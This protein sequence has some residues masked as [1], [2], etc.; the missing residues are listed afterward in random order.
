MENIKIIPQ[1]LRGAISVPP[2]KSLCHRALI[3]ASLC[4]DESI[5]SNISMSQDIKAT[6]SLIKNMGVDL[7]F[8]DSVVKI[9]GSGKLK[10]INRDMD[11]NESGSTLR[12]FIP[13]LLTIGEGVTFSGKGK[14]VERPLQPYYSI[15]DEQD[16]KY[17]TINGMLPLTVEGIL[18]PGDFYIS[19]DVSSQFVT[20]LLFALP[21]LQKDSCIHITS[22]LESSPYVDLT[23]DILK[24]FSVNI[25]NHEYK[26]FYIK[27]KQKYKAINYYVE[28]DYSQAAFW[29]A[30]GVIGNNVT[31]RGLNINSLQGDKVIIDIL[32]EMGGIISRKGDSIT[33]EGSRLNGIS[34]DASQCP[35]LVPILAV[36]GSLAEGTTKIYNAARVRI[37]ECDR[38]KAIATELNKI[39]AD[40]YEEEDALVIHGKRTLKGGVVNSWNDH[41]I[42]MALAIAAICCEEP[43]IITDSEAIGKSYPTFF[44]D[45]LSLGGDF[46]EWNMG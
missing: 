7:T 30:A 6:S 22:K 16:I 13:I 42:V 9:N 29:L 5:I 8:L 12:F 17:S 19:G 18:K 44:S 39:G 14:L 4:E 40:V 33:A 10:V 20:G 43:L 46:N 15:F 31:C 35:D 24:K 23:I 25:D 34:I 37:K 41:R 36:L 27:G 1:K 3:A 21:L 11:C 26:E 45:Y 32:K 2:S 38:L 28:G